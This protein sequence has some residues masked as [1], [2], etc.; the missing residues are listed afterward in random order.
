MDDRTLQFALYLVIAAA[1]YVLVIV[2]IEIVRRVL[3]HTRAAR[4]A[5]NPVVVGHDAPRN[6]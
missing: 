4:V 1:L 2:G 3:N 6:D 5:R